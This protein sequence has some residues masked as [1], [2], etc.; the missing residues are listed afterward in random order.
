MGKTKSLSR[1]DFLKGALVAGGVLTAGGIAARLYHDYSGRDFDVQRSLDQLA[2]VSK[3]DDP[4][5]LPNIIIFLVDDLGYGDLTGY[6]RDLINTPS[7]D[8]MTAEGVSMDR[9][10]AAAPVCT[11]SRAGL[12]TGRYPIRSH[13]VLPAYPP[14]APMGWFLNAI[15]RFPYGVTGVPEDELLLPELLRQRGYN[16]ALVGKWHL[17]GARKYWPTKHG[18]EFFYGPLYSNDMPKFE[19][20]QDD[21]VA[22]PHS[23]DQNLLTR[24]YT[25]K[26]LGFIEEHRERPFFL[27]LAHTMV[28]EPLHASAAFRGTS[29]AGLYGDAVQELDWSLGQILGALSELGIDE[30]TFLVFTSDNGPWWQGSSGGLRGRKNNISEGGFRV[31]FIARWP[32]ILPAGA[33]SDELAVNFDLF[34]TCLQ[35]AGVPVPNDRI[36]DGRDMLPVLQGRAASTHDTFY[37]YFGHVLVAVRHNNYKYHRRYLSDNGGYPIFRHGPFLFDLERDPAESYSLIE[38]EPEVAARMAGM[39]DDWEQSIDAN[40]RGWLP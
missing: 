8:R 32:G 39:L 30:N 15:G 12:L 24:N 3:A 36:I 34:T 18:F 21:Q 40:V 28:H 25:E 9:F 22:M 11:P 7:L 38:S 5:K 13:L 23:V 14:G 10:Y 6:S 1:R 37:Y 31:P 29:H 35:L 26:A 33:T 16:T 20:Y 17:G 2:R 4:G 27:L 19:V